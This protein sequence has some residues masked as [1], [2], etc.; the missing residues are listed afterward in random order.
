MGT[1]KPSIFIELIVHYK[2]FNHWGTTVLGNLHVYLYNTLYTI[3]YIYMFV[4]TSWSCNIVKIE[5]V[6]IIVAISI[7]NLY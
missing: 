4:C 6:L 7:V 3:Y 1:P 2:P 5:K